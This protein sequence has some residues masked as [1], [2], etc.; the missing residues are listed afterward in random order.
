MFLQH[1]DGSA[2]RSHDRAARVTL[3]APAF[4]QGLPPCVLNLPHNLL[5]QIGHSL[6][7]AVLWCQLLVRVQDARV[8]AYL[9]QLS[10]RLAVDRVHSLRCLLALLTRHLA[11]RHAR[12]TQCQRHNQHSGGKRR[13]NSPLLSTKIALIPNH[14]HWGTAPTGTR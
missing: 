10:R 8:N 1:E 3:L 7:P 12:G 5:K 6:R 11:V 13:V 9:V 14:N 4:G 2:K